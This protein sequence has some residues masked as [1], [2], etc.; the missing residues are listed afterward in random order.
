MTMH[1]G[2]HTCGR[3]VYKP[4]IYSIYIY[5]L[6]LGYIYTAVLQS[7]VVP[8]SVGHVNSMHLQTIIILSA[9]SAQRSQHKAAAAE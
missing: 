2:Q 8:I 1:P 4:T 7:P 3:H 9:E 5:H 6:P